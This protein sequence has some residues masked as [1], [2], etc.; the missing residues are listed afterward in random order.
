MKKLLSILIL[1][2]ATLPNLKAQDYL[3]FANSN[4]SGISG[5]HL[6]PAYMVDSRYKVDINLV[7][8]GFN[9]H[10]NYVGLKPGA[11]FHQKGA[12][13]LEF[14]RFSDSTF[15]DNYLT[16][17][18]GGKNKSVF[19]NA[20]LSAPSFLITIDR[21]SAIGFNWRVRSYTNVDGVEPELAQLIYNELIVPSLW[22]RD[23]QNERFSVQTNT[24]AEYGLSYG[25]VIKD[26]GKHYMKVAGTAKLLQGLGSAY[27]FADNLDYEFI[28]DSIVNFNNFEVNYGHS[29]NFE[30]DQGNLKYKF[31]SKFSMGADLG[32]VYEWRPDA[33]DAHHEKYQYNM[34]GETNLW[35]RYKTPYKLRIGASLMDIG[36]VRYLKGPESRNFQANFDSLNINVF[37][38]ED[39][40]IADFDSTLN[41]LF[42]S[43]PDVGKFNM[44][45]P[46]AFSLQV[47][48]H[49]WGDFY[50]NMTTYAA[51]QFK[52]KES[53]IHDITTI[54]LAP[55]W[56][57]KW[58]GMSIPFSWNATGNTQFGAMLRIGPLVIG[59]NNLSSIMAY[60]KNGDSKKDIY[61]ADIYALL[62]IPI[63]YGKV[64]DRD[65]DE[66]SDKKDLCIDQ[67]GIWAF[68]GC[69]DRDKDG[70]QD[71]EDACPD[72][73]GTLEFKG[74][75]D[76]D[77]DKIIDKLDA[78]PEEAGLPEF[79]GCPD[80]DG[81]KIIDSKD[82]CPDTPGLEEFNGC[83]DKDG[84]K[85]PD[86]KDD[87]PDVAGA[88]EFIGC[89]DTDGDK[90][91]DIDDKCPTK[92][93]PQHNWGCPEIK[94]QLLAYGNKVLE[95]VTIED[96][97]FNFKTNFDKTK[98]YFKLIT[99]EGDTLS[100]IM[101]TS[102][103]LRGKKAF[104]DADGYFR[105]PKEA[106]T[107][108]LTIEEQEIVKKAFDNLEFA[109]GKAVIKAESNSALD[110]LAELMKKH[111]GWKLKIE[112][113][114]D[115][116]GKASSNTLLSKNRAN[117]VKTYLTKKGVAAT[118]FEVKWYG[119][120]KPIADNSTEEGRQKNRRV[121]MTLME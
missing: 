51:F 28:N 62:K 87:C 89:P 12:N 78:C 3:G 81:D 90:L 94:L 83:P 44:K 52:K 69:P 108:Q 47:D 57:H 119:P 70:I 46:T 14:P 63:P 96:S 97:K 32:F 120:D 68:K 116:V 6:N 102:P 86:H 103:E 85:L 16:V 98:A 65:K 113:H 79:N 115:N 21:K 93:G 55:R 38:F 24:W 27:L 118:R 15:Q 101:I 112:G 50:V 11:L 35:Y 18:D 4:Y 91:R 109:T 82:E 30:F 61:G 77:G 117:A 23:F 48:Y 64:K 45:L 29:T 25:R 56:D 75:P 8:F 80:R 58:F 73:P 95:E 110:E 88:I 74:C 13:G 54:S 111:A 26:D 99:S 43:T 9:V 1:V 53:K 100:Q 71:S 37:Q 92:P 84:D 114:T 49:I 33:E 7:G 66:I 104:L 42:T 41:T 121:E 17:N 5:V 40:P 106:E 10:N 2:C 76:K 67:P 34:D 20:H 105:F 107:V 59:T 31:F 36:S 19:L 72:E 60:A 22:L 39:T